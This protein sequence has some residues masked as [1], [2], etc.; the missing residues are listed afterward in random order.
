[1]LLALVART[2]M[3]LALVA[4]IKNYNIPITGQY[5]E[6]IPNKCSSNKV[7]SGSTVKIWSTQFVP[8]KNSFFRT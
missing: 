6:V 3:L 7:L 2:K 8:L 4:H 1:M 5:P